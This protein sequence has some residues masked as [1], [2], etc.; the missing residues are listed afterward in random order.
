MGESHID[1]SHVCPSPW[2]G[3]W[4]HL[5]DIVS[6][7]YI[8]SVA[9]L[10]TVACNREQAYLISPEQHDAS[11]LHHLLTMLTRQKADMFRAEENFV[12]DGRYYPAGTIIVPL[13]QPN[14][15]A[16]RMLFE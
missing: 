5:S 6:Q 15:G 7:M 16:R 11:A 1:R 13:N 2:P 12:S 4:W 3:G 10:K 8:S 9:L 14:Y